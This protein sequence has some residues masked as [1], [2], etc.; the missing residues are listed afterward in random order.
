[1]LVAAP[2]IAMIALGGIVMAAAWRDAREMDRLRNMFV[3]VEQ[4]GQL[5]HDLQKERGMSAVF[6]N[7]KGTQFANELPAQRREVDGRDAEFRRAMAALDTASLPE[8][9]AQALRDA[10]QAMRGLPAWRE[11]VSRQSVSGPDS[12]QFFGKLIDALLTV[13]RMAIHLS[14]DAKSTAALIAYSNYIQAKERAGRERA[15][16]AVG[17]TAGR[18]DQATFTQWTTIVGVYAIMLDGFSHFA[19]P[20][21]AGYIQEIVAGPVVE[22]YTRLRDVALKAGPNGDLQGITAADWFRASTDRIDLMKRAEDRLAV[23]V[24]ALIDQR[25]SAARM[26]ERVTAACIAVALGLAGVLAWTLSRGIT[27]PIGQMAAFMRRLASGDVDGEVPGQGNRDEIGVM[28]QAVVTFQQS[29][30]DNA[31]LAAEQA[32]VRERQ[33][34][35]TETLDGLTRAFDAAASNRITEVEG[36]GSRMHDTAAAISDIAGRTR[37]RAAEVSAE[38]DKAAANVQAVAAAADQLSAS[39]AEIGRQ[40]AQSASVTEQTVTAVQQ[41]DGVVRAL[42]DGA[43]AIGDVV[44]LINTIASQTN[45]LALNATIEAA[46]AGEAGKGFAVVA[47]EVKGLASQTSRA[48]DDIARQIDNIQ[49]ATREAV[50]AIGGIGGRIEEVNRIAAAIAAA[51]EEQGAATA[52]IARSAQDVA[53]GAAQVTKVIGLVDQDTQKMTEASTDVMQSAEGMANQTRALGDEVRGFL[54]SVKAA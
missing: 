17:F 2:A 6:L 5:V 52:E 33:V 30:R 18:F 15:I 35:R 14:P 26:T 8:A 31:R 10:D 9:V 27:R 40:V 4:L 13:S 22:T 39:I 29:L 53:L 25:A 12:F 11:R 43:R 51:V 42:D 19:T 41:T 37:S 36:A 47:A 16:G 45:L 7:S 34:Q 28:A 32:T 54:A 48:T 24:A 20:A 49:S 44:S 1:M 3:I 23:D 46:R 38:S 50:A 21:Q